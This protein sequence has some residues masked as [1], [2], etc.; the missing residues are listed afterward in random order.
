[1]LRGALKGQFDERL[2]YLYGLAEGRDP[3]R[4]LASAEAWLKAHPEH[5]GLL[6]S[7]GR[8]ALRNHLWGKA[9]DYFEHSL[10][11]ERSAETYGELARLL[12]RLGEL[13]RSN[14]LLQEGFG[15]LARDLPV[16]PQPG[17]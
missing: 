8:L 15:L 6:L 7:L 14:R 4:Q 9:R 16:L 5:P 11:L 13:E 10:R 3:A 17:R 1:M 12:A 2:A